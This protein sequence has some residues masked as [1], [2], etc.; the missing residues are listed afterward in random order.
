MFLVS[1]SLLLLELNFLNDLNFS[2]KTVHFFA[3]STICYVCNLFLFRTAS[4]YTSKNIF[5]LCLLALNKITYF[6]QACNV[7]LPFADNIT[8]AMSAYN[9]GINGHLWW[10]LFTVGVTILP[11]FCA[12]LLEMLPNW[13]LLFRWFHGEHNRELTGDLKISRPQDLLKFRNELRKFREDL[14]LASLNLPFVGSVR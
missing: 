4:S 9:L 5:M 6:F 13:K 14:L 12:F 7:I 8:D 3:S 11:A 1:D 10:A 2:M